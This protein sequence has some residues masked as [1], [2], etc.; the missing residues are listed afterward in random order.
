MVAFAGEDGGC[1][2]SS[3][4][5]KGAEILLEHCQTGKLPGVWVE[6]RFEERERETRLCFEESQWN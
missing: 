1:V 6:F 5:Q 4:I 2:G 3:K